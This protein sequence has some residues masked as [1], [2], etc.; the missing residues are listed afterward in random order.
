MR[1]KLFSSLIFSYSTCRQVDQWMDGKQCIRVHT[2]LAQVSSKIVANGRIFRAKSGT[3][4]IFAFVY[5]GQLTTSAS[6]DVSGI[7]C[8]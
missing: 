2:A 3:F 7:F 6:A 5:W 8:N 1:Y 4:K